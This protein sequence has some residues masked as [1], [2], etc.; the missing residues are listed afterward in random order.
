MQLKRIKETVLI[1]SLISFFLILIKI[2][3]EETPFIDSYLGQGA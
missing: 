1:Y 3:K 2:N